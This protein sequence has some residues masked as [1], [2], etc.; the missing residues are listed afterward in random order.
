[1]AEG[2]AIPYGVYDIA[3]DSAMVSV[4]IDHDTAQL[5]VAAIG[6]WWEQ[7]GKARYPAAD[8]L[9][10]TADCG[11]SNG[12]RTRLWKT[13]LQRLA[14]H[15]GLAIR[16]YHFPPGTSKWNKNRA[17]P[18]QLH[19]QELAR[20]AADLLRSHRQPD[21]RDDHQHRPS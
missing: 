1:M 3:D 9:T 20:A 8:T 7:L 12:N 18:V 10:I 16:V 4:G 6:A 21:R 17:P 19:L 13:E 15:T 11:G 5:S 14:D 2:K